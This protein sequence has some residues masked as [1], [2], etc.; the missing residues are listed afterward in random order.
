MSI[1]EL[2]NNTS[3]PNKSCDMNDLAMDG[4]PIKYIQNPSEAVFAA[5][6]LLKNDVVYFDTE[7]A[8]FVINDPRSGNLRLL[9]FF[10]GTAVTIFDWSKVSSAYAAIQTIFKRCAVVG[11]N[12][13]FDLWFIKKTLDVL[14][15]HCLDTLICSRFVSGPRR[16]VEHGLAPCL[17]RH[18]GI[19]MDKTL[20]TSDWAAETLS[21]EQIQYASKDVLHLP[22]LSYSLI[23]KLNTG[24]DVPASRIKLGDLQEPYERLFNLRHQSCIVECA[25]LPSTISLESTG[26]A[27]HRK[28]LEEKAKELEQTYQARLFKFNEE[29]PNAGGPFCQARIANILETAGF[30]LSKTKNNKLSIAKEVL[31]DL[32]GKHPLV[33]ALLD[34]RKIKN[35]LDYCHGLLETL[36]DSGRVHTHFTQMNVVSSRMSS[37]NPNIQNPPKDPVIRSLFVAQPGYKL[38]SADLPQIEMRVGAVY[39]NDR[40]LVRLFEEGRDIYLEMVR[41]LMGASQF[42]QLSDQAKKEHRNKSKPGT[43]ATLFAMSAGGFVDYAHETF[44]INITREFAEQF[45]KAFFKA[46]PGIAHYHAAA[47]ENLRKN[48]SIFVYTLLGRKLMARTVQEVCNYPVQSSTCE[49]L[50]IAVLLLRQKVVDALP[51]PQCR[52]VNLIH[53]DVVLEV[54]DKDVDA[55]RPMLQSSLAQAGRLL[56]IPIQDSDIA[57]KVGPNWE[58]I[59]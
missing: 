50:K 35:H 39:M 30:K 4:F 45:Q 36:V 19:E 33:D 57:V 44:G 9:T 27:I 24:S 49:L 16:D 3:T 47:R 26:I 43:L 52:L 8:N 59:K 53:D 28:S 25:F 6:A 17:Q 18:L 32:K 10:D 56:G 58:Q 34:I 21:I 20:Q 23:E 7:I 46:F 15:K 31:T 11:H 40:N 42:D 29:F 37:S 13:H 22:A 12:L 55:V 38:M 41:N 5:M 54:L 14:P 1:P 2:F 51:R 48:G